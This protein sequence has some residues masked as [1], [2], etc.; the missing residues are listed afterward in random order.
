MSNFTRNFY[1]ILTEIC[2][3]DG[4]GL[5]TYSDGWTF[6]LQKGERRMFILGYNFGMNS[7]AVA[8]ICT[9]KGAASDI[10]R[11]L[12]IPHVEHESFRSPR[13]SVVHS[14]WDRLS[15]LLNVHG[16]L[17]CKPN[18][19]TCGNQVYLVTSKEELEKAYYDIFRNN[20]AMAVSPYYNIEEEYRFVVLNGE[21]KL[22]Y[23]K[24]RRY[25][26]GDGASSIGQLI[27]SYVRINNINTRIVDIPEAETR[28][29]PITG[30]IVLL[31]W[32]HNLSKGSVAFVREL[33]DIDVS[34]LDMVKSLA[35]EMGLT[36]A[37]VD[38][39]KCQ[40][41]YRVMEINSSVM[42]EHFAGQDVVCYGLAKEIYRE[43]ISSV[44]G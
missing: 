33:S 43:A 37:S 19:G 32:K 24:F 20:D 36:F 10:M 23:S 12:D 22:V 35:V 29:V 42:M 6:E 40:D 44:L 28:R 34:V 15:E 31:N 13:L 5:H 30:E 39:I 18:N 27:Q 16:R 17:V 7:S 4:I 41:G 1:K 3:E 2:E 9:D 21:I 11:R 38:V 26:V 8:S 14:C 25:V